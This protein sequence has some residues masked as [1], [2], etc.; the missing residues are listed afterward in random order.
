MIALVLVAVGSSGGCAFLDRV[1]VSAGGADPDGPSGIGGVAV[2][3]DGRYVAFVSSA[4]NLVPGVPSG[5]HVY[6]RDVLTDATE[7]VS[8]SSEEVPAE[9]A[10]S[11]PSMSADGRYVAFESDASNLVADDGNGYDDVFVRDR[12]SGTTERVSVATGGAEGDYLSVE[13]SIS[14]D[15]RH[16]AFTSGASNL[17]AGDGNGADDVFV[18][19]RVTGT[20]ERVSVETGGS[21][22][23][24]LEDSAT[25]SISGDGRYVAFS[26]YDAFVY[27]DVNQNE[28]VYLRDRA[29]G[30]TTMV[31]RTNGG[32]VS[33]NGTTGAPSISADGRYVAFAS[34][35][36]LAGT[37]PPVATIVYV[38]DLVQGKSTRACAGIGGAPANGACGLPSISADGRYVAFRSLASNLVSGDA[39]GVSDVFVHDR[40]TA[41]TVVASTDLL[42]GPG[43]SATAVSAISGDGKYV[44]F[45]TASAMQSFGPADA[46]VA[47]DVYLRFAMPPSVVSTSPLRVARGTS[48]T[49]LVNGSGFRSPATMW[50]DT[51]GVTFGAATVVSDTLIVT[52]VT[53]A[54]TVAA[55]AVTVAVQSPGAAWDPW[56]GALGRCTTCLAAT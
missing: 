19:D 50:T 3:H 10:A 36:A 29:T 56:T 40:Q 4:T 42:L 45:A 35:A 31:S 46:N 34:D 21:E 24:D 39:N 22:G 18:H 37:D 2:S 15:G 11:A 26:S 41:R 23:P 48:G 17:V 6:V 49:L 51:P 43:P 27:G 16:V 47:H 25:P 44:A 9:S 14:A 5:T 33:I 52:S 54:S 7:L 1:S 20:T 13:P 53:V 30:T 38:R 8:V 55:G 32:D 12:V 28:D